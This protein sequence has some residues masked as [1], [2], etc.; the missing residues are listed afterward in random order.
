MGDVMGVEGGVVGGVVGGVGAP[1][2]PNLPPVTR[3]DVPTTSISDLVTSGAGV[4]TA[5][6]PVSVGDLFDYRVTTPVSVA[7]GHSALLPI[8][9]ERLEG[10]QVSLWRPSCRDHRPLAA[11]RLRNTST[12]TLEAGPITVLDGDVYAGEA[13]LERIRP[14]E[15]Q[16]VAYA[17]DLATLVE[18]RTKRERGPAFFL[19]IEDGTLEAHYYQ[20]RTT[21]YA[22]TNQSERPRTLYIE[23]LRESPWQRAPTGPQPV[24][25][26]D[27]VWRFRVELPPK[28]QIELPV[29]ERKGLQDRYSLEA[30]S[31]AN[32]AALEAQGFLD[33][34]SRPP[35]QRILAVRS[36][37]E[38]LVERAK[39]AE[40]ETTAL[41]ADQRRL[42]ANVQSASRTSQGRDLVRRWLALAAA[43]ESR[44]AALAAETEASKLERAQLE[45]ELRT[46]VKRLRLERQL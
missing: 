37:L 7:R 22:L 13:S 4:E 1:S 25:S 15:E 19:R 24:E 18:T 6:R 23:H 20:L 27:E 36:R 2:L 8:L 11:L 17:V 46:T 38:E 12:L 28:K 16:T 41:A 43:D 35:L 26:R 14:D 10:E 40:I 39:V 34:N 32:L 44:L 45:A 9:Q 29:V 33:E 42:S 30:F 5:A 21:V 31:Q 3:P